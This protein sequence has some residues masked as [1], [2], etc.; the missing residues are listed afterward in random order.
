MLRVGAS[1][2][3]QRFI[4][5]LRQLAYVLDQRIEHGLRILASRLH[6]NH[7]PARAFNQRCDLAIGI[8]K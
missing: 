8:T 3:G 1:I 2:P 7:E 5:L 4:E 6:Q